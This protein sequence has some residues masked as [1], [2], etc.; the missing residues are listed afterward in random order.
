MNQENWLVFIFRSFRELVKREHIH[1]LCGKTWTLVTDSCMN[2]IMSIST[3]TNATKPIN[4]TVNWHGRRRLLPKTMKFMAFD[5]MYLAKPLPVI[6]FFVCRSIFN[7]NFHV[8]SGISLWFFEHVI[9]QMDKTQANLR[10]DSIPRKQNDRWTLKQH[11]KWSLPPIHIKTNR[12]Q[13]LIKSCRA[14]YYVCVYKLSSGKMKNVTINHRN[15]NRFDK[16]LISTEKLIFIVR[17]NEIRRQ[18]MVL[19]SINCLW[20]LPFIKMWARR[21]ITE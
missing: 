1:S 13:L 8:G 2:E 11:I 10:T 4:S 15:G 3:H 17:T 20:Y 18:I 16:Q 9:H 5:N 21:S 7:C 19:K 6:L 14:F 12:P